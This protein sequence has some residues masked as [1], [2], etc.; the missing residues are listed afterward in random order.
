[1][2]NIA[3]KIHLSYN[4]LKSIYTK[5]YLSINNYYIEIR[6]VKIQLLE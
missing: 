5:V 2:Y 1:M 6:H 3:S 4:S